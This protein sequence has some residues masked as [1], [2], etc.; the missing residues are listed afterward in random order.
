MIFERVSK[1]SHPNE[2]RGRERKEGGSSLMSE[3]GEAERERESESE[4]RMRKW[5]LAKAEWKLSLFLM[6][7]SH[8][9]FLIIQKRTKK[10]RRNLFFLRSEKEP[11]TGEFF[12][13]WLQ[14]NWSQKSRVSNISSR[15]S[16]TFKWQGFVKKTKKKFHFV[17]F[18]LRIVIIHYFA[19]N[20]SAGGESHSGDS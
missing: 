16:F 20:S 4:M 2:E 5:T 9:D 8:N 19:S 10:F 18:F 1:I 6:N 13:N 12:I 14:I 7:E 11:R 3:T 17:I 15:F